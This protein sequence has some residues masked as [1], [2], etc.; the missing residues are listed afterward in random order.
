MNPPRSVIL[1]R[2]VFGIAFFQPIVSGGEETG[3]K[4]PNLRQLTK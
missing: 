2:N 4:L 3:D 1:G